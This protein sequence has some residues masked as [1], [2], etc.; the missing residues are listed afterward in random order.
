[1]VRYRGLEKLLLG[2]IVF[3]LILYS[4]CIQLGEKPPAGKGILNLTKKYSKYG[5]S[6]WYPEGM[7]IT[8][9]ALLGDYPDDN[10]GIIFGEYRPNK[11]EVLFIG[12]TWMKIPVVLPSSD[13]EEYRLLNDSLSSF[14]EGMEE[15]AKITK[16]E[17]GEIKVNKRRVLYQKYLSSTDEYPEK[18]L[19]G[20]VGSFYCYKNRNVYVFD[21]SYSKD[22]NE[23]FLLFKE[24]LE[25]F[26][27]Y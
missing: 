24:F 12:I 13:E 1:M 9:R 4:G 21:L 10:S 15:E 11:K 17:K 8:E 3:V 14:L 16:K 2:C 20:V 6:F 25:N 26:D 7:E 22:K 5:F 19:Y 27:C 18:I 23:S